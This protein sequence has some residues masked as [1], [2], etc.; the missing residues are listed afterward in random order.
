MT[1]PLITFHYFPRYA[2][3]E[4]HRGKVK[5]LA[6]WNEHIPLIVVSLANAV[7]VNNLF[8]DNEPAH[9]RTNSQAS[10]TNPFCSTI[11]LLLIYTW[12]SSYNRYSAT[13]RCTEHKRSTEKETRPQTQASNSSKVR[14][15]LWFKTSVQHFTEYS[16]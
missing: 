4:D 8:R 12:I 9:V 2:S 7:P 10:S 15:K 3:R 14:K 5:W 11:V 6:F 13:N 16:R 1:I